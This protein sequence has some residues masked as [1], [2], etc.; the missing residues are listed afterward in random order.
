MSDRPKKEIFQGYFQRS[1]SGFKVYVS[2]TAYDKSDE[3]EGEPLKLIDDEL[4]KIADILD[5]DILKVVQKVPVWVEWDHA[6]LDQNLQNRHAIGAYYKGTS[7]ALIGE[8]IDPRKAGCV[9]IVSLRLA[10]K[11]KKDGGTQN[12]LLHEFAHV[13]HDLVWKSDNPFVI[14]AFNQAL[15]R[16]LYEQVRFDNGKIGQAYASQ[17]HKEY[18]AELTCAYLDKLDYEPHNRKEL[19]EYDSV[20]YEIMTKAW[21]TPEQ[22]EERKKAAAAKKKK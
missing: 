21:G 2:R 6:I 20:G 18:F 7:A 8:G 22:I 3:A 17:S 9:S 11:I 4:T 15:A 19:K 14:S 1:Q 10:H 5:P 16:K 12:T 13:M